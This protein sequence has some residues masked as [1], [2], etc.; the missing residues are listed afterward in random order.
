MAN[1]SMTDT[2]TLN[3]FGFVVV[4]TFDFMKRRPPQRSSSEH[5]FDVFTE[6]FP[7]LQNEIQIETNRTLLLRNRQLHTVYL[8]Q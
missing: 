4:F 1:F 6:T 2:A 7:F 8:R 3:F 5:F